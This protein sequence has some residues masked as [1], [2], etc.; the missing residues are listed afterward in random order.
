MLTDK[1]EFRPRYDEVDRMGYLYH[2]NHISY[3]HQARTEMMRKLG[4]HDAEIEKQGFMMPVI[5]FNIQY[6]TPAK[7]DELLTITTTIKEVPKIRFYFEY[8]IR[9]EKGELVSKSNSQVVFVDKQS[10]KPMLVPDFVLEGLG[11]NKHET[12]VVE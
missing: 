5:E 7:Y 6:K 4:I 12:L 3:C 10:R 2:A 8:E 1:F 9:N 11:V